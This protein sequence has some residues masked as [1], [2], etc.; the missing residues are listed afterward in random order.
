MRSEE[1]TPHRHRWLYRGLHKHLTAPCEPEVL[2]K[3]EIG[4]IHEHLVE[5]RRLMTGTVAPY[6][7]LHLAD[8]WIAYLVTQFAAVEANLDLLVGPDRRRDVRCTDCCAA[9]A[10]ASNAACSP[11]GPLPVAGRSN[12]S[13]LFWGSARPRSNACRS[14]PIGRPGGVPSAVS[15]IGS[16]TR[17][18]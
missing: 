2:R 4:E 3:Y 6:A 16:F 12:C 1:E 11:D 5:I 18:Q 8:Q 17:Q 7:A 15:D 9:R 10:G 14:D 13:F